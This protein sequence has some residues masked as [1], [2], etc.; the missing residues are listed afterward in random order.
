VVWHSRPGDDAATLGIYPDQ[1]DA[2]TATSILAEASADV[3]IVG[4]THLTFEARLADGRRIVN[5][6]AL[7]RDPE[8]DERPRALILGAHGEQEIARI[9]GGRFGVL[10]LPTREFTVRD[11]ASGAVVEHQVFVLGLTNLR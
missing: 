6:G 8:A 3:L 7:W 11:A 1:L 4:H 5:A 9:D 10:E 2:K